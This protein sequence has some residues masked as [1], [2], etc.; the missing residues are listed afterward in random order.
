MGFNSLSDNWFTVSAS[1]RFAA[2]AETAA[3]AASG[4]NKSHENSEKDGRVSQS[5]HDLSEF[6]FDVFWSFHVHYGVAGFVA[7]V[8]GGDADGSSFNDWFVIIV[9][10]K[11]TPFELHL[12]AHS[13]ASSFFVSDDFRG[14]NG[15]IEVVL[16]PEISHD[17]VAAFQWVWANV[18]RNH[19]GL[20]VKHWVNRNTG[21]L[22][23]PFQSPPSNIQI[24]LISGVLQNRQ[25]RV[26]F[27]TLF[28][29]LW[30]PWKSV[31]TS[32]SVGNIFSE[33]E[34]VG[35]GEKLFG[36]EF[37]G[38]S[39]EVGAGLVVGVGSPNLLGGNGGEGRGSREGGGNELHVF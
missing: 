37:G 25:I 20:A 36:A 26:N 12:F 34:R 10:V 6:F 21:P 2:A 19:L 33:N 16:V 22:T 31:Q 13:N 18:V 1:A 9:A 29:A 30:A 23:D 14:E 5:V 35:N 7:F 8:I 15:F 28:F 39:W 11:V 32:A 4:D 27:D 38:E 17:A 24:T 3:E